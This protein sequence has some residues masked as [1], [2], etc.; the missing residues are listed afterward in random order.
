MK[1]KQYAFATFELLREVINTP[2]R[3]QH[4]KQQAAG[5]ILFRWTWKTN[6]RLDANSGG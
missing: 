3:Q 4:D 6:G 2:T 1:I 5:L